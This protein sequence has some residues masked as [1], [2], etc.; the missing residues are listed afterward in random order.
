MGTTAQYPHIKVDASGAARID[1]TRYKVEHLA[2]EH[3]HHG[4]TAEELLRQHSDLQPAQ[5]YAALAYFYDYREAIIAQLESTA[6]AA[7]NARQSQS[8]S[9]DELLRR[10]ASNYR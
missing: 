6:Q 3:F 9:R 2:A 7:D 8:L 4:W 1:D 5:V 10:Q